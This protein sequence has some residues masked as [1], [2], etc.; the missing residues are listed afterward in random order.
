MK[1]SVLIVALC[2][3]ATVAFAKPAKVAGWKDVA[4]IANKNN[5][6]VVNDEQLWYVAKGNGGKD[7]ALFAEKVFDDARVTVAMSC[8]KGEVFSKT[9]VVDLVDGQP[10]PIFTLGLD[11]DKVRNVN[12]DNLTIYFNDE[13]IAMWTDVAKEQRADI[14]NDIAKEFGLSIPKN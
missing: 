3:L 12:A 8:V 5:M 7:F 14:L 1:K 13:G 6:E 11:D 10:N 2:A 9:T 4:K